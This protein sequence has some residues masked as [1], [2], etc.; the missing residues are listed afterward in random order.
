MD[1]DLHMSVKQ[2]L[3]DY[4]DGLSD[5]EARSLWDRIRCDDYE[6]SVQQ[7]LSEDDRAS[8]WRGIA[9]ADAGRMMSHGDV[10]QKFGLS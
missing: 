5:E 8:I 9:D 2:E 6:W 10:K 1:Y 3:R 4:I 7:P